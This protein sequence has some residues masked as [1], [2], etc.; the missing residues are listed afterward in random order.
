LESEL[1]LEEQKPTLD[2][3]GASTLDPLDRIERM[4]AAESGSDEQ[5]D[6]Q[7]DGTAE[8]KA[9]TDDGAP[10]DDQQPQLSTSDLAKLLGLEDDALDLDEDGSVKIK[11]KIDGK[12][13]APKL[14]DLVK[15]YQVQGHADNR[16]REVAKQEE[17][18]RAREQEAEQQF[19][20]R[21]KYAENLTNIA[22]QQLLAE[23]QSIDWKTL[24]QT[25]P[26]TAAL[27]RQKFQERHAQLQGVHN[28][29][30]QEKAQADQKSQAEKHAALAKEAAR[31]PEL[32][33]EWKDAAVAAKERAELREWAI[34]AGYEP[35]EVDSISKAHHVAVL[36]KAMLADKLK[37]TQ[38]AI[39]NK[40]RAAPKLVKPG[41]PAANAQEQSLRN[42]K[43]S[44][45]KSG[46]K[47]GAVEQ[48]LL[49]TGRV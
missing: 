5:P 41:Q 26:G 46:G 13:V 23:F 33:P 42:L 16:A 31:L 6:S 2:T 21:L 32:I 12:E 4:L 14:A 3:E 7:E 27:W 48:Y 20:E 18:L 17:A 28:N 11:T 36:R 45:Q 34:K 8:D 19:S 44:V 22:A 35:E 38:P 1:T 24:E 10:D 29:I 40:V 49:A 15:S 9:V 39:E 30:Q 43:L 37:A 25:D 47:N